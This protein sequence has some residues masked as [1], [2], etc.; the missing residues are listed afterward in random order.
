MTGGEHN[1]PVANPP[2]NSTLYYYLRLVGFVDDVGQYP[3]VLLLL[4]PH[5]LAVVVLDVVGQH[6]QLVTY[7]SRGMAKMALFTNSTRGFVPS[8]ATALLIV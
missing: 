1:P 6:A 4:Y 5:K 7:F 8:A 3:E 2:C